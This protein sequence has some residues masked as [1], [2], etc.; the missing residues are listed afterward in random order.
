VAS[1]ETLT[2]HACQCH[3]AQEYLSKSASPNPCSPL[4]Y[5][6]LPLRNQIYGLRVCFALL[7]EHPRSKRCRRVTLGHGASALHDDRPGVVALVGE[8]DCTAA[9]LTTRREHRLMHMP[10]EHPRPAK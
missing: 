6:H 5:L 7:L 8:M 2:S 4:L 9:H 10:P 1:P 3:R